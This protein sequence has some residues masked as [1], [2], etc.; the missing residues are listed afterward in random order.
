MKVEVTSFRTTI[1]R[2]YMAIMTEVPAEAPENHIA[3]TQAVKGE[4][5]IKR[6]CRGLGSK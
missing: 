4:L 6:Q 2:S 3:V 1:L 5:S